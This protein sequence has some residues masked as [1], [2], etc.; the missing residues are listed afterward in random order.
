M[1]YWSEP[2]HLVQSVQQWDPG[3]LAHHGPVP[4]LAIN[5][6]PQKSRVALEEDF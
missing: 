2:D 3:L 1:S 4:F 5:E 6:R